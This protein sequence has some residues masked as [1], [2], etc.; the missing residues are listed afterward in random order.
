MTKNSLE[1]EWSA[2]G[3]PEQGLTTEAPKTHGGQS[4]IQMYL[5]S[6]KAPH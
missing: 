4:V 1:E 2:L 6:G 3:S 5:K